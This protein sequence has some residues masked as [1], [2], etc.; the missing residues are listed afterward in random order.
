MA[1]VDELITLLGL[2]VDP[3]A[4]T[5]ARGFQESITA[6]KNTAIVAG[7]ALLALAGATA[8]TSKG[9]AAAADQSKK[10]ADS[11]DFDFASLQELEF[12]T[13][14]SGGSVEGLRA[15]LVTL[16][17]TYGDG[18]AAIARLA[19]RF[20]GLSNRRAQ[21]L[22]DSLGLSQDTILLLQQGTAGIAKLR[23]EARQLG[24]IIPDDLAKQTAEFND[25]L[26]NLEAI[27]SGINN[28]LQ[29]ALI[30]SFTEATQS[31]RV[32]LVENEEL[33]G[34]GLE[35][36]IDGVQL[37]FSQFGDIIDTVASTV[38]D[39]IGPL[40]GMIEG[41]EFAGIIGNTVTGVLV[42]LAVA[43]TPIAIKFIAI[44]AAI[45]AVIVIVDDLITYIQGG[46]SAIGSFLD[47]FEQRFPALFDLVSSAAGIFG[48]FFSMVIDGWKMIGDAI[49]DLLPSVSDL[50]VGIG[51]A[52]ESFAEF[53]GFG[54]DE[55]RVSAAPTSAP[56]PASIINSSN[57][58]RGGDVNQTFNI[59]GSQ[60]PRL[61]ASEV[62]RK[63]SF[64]NM[65]QAL[66][67]GQ[68]APRTA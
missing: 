34:S 22:G 7:T 16:N 54:G 15:D 31:L 9:F 23:A 21:Q 37:G 43:L 33:I 68:R 42:A 60:D 63:S 58:Q 47:A 8:A 55:P 66:A 3:K 50:A 6:V 64:G 67:P 48:D 46:E 14:R 1:V 40:D 4:E 49:L 62:A 61:V 30:P 24:G 27:T 65:T 13:K 28:R 51:D 53:L 56:V 29:A 39:F 59:D 41:L 2:E 52:L 26:T 45:A 57:V 38:L 10:F 32:F 12:A 36:F 25:E 5:E 18:E 19:A 20:D 17:N 11:L 44:A 35:E